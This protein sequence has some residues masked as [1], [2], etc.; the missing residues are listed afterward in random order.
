MDR[1]CRLNQPALDI[2]YLDSANQSIT[3]VKLENFLPLAELSEKVRLNVLEKILR[4]LNR[5]RESY[6]CASEDFGHYLKESVSLVNKYY[7]FKN[8]YQ[9][10]QNSFYDSEMFFSIQD[11]II[12]IDQKPFLTGC[13]HKLL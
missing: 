11:V 1:I 10:L 8:N 5:A 12:A 3:Y 4:D 13:A 9:N 7:M 6:C 2:E